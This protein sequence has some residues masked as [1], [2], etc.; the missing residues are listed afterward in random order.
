MTSA[1]AAAS[2]ELVA[3]AAGEPFRLAGVAS[4]ATA[5]AL[6]ERG[7]AL[8]G[9]LAEVELDLSAVTHVDS[10][11]LA[12]LLTWIERARR[13]GRVLRYRSIPAQ[14]RGIARISAV[15][16]MLQAAEARR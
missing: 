10:A 2:F 12:V 13:G 1:A 9:T 15:E 11:G 8:F 16:E 3:G 14:L 6:L 4:L 5:R 7:S